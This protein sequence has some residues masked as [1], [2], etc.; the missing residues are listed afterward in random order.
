MSNYSHD[1]KSAMANRAFASSIKKFLA[2]GK[3]EL[4]E[5][6]KNKLTYE[7]VY[8]FGRGEQPAVPSKQKAHLYVVSALYQIKLNRIF[9]DKASQCIGT[10]FWPCAFCSVDILMSWDE[11]ALKYAETITCHCKPGIEQRTI[12][13]WKFD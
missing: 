6:V 8:L 2:D 4:P 10:A 13:A 5:K 7:Y 12:H 11:I 9:S 3:P 1:T